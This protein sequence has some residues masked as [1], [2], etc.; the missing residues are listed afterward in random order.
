MKKLIHIVGARPQFVKLAPFVHKS[1]GMFDNIVIHTGQHY[2]AAMSAS[3]FADL[4]I[5]EPDYNL[6]VGSGN[7][8]DQTG[9]MLSGIEALLLKENPDAVI[10][11]GDTN[12]TLAGALAAAKLGIYTMH[13][14]ACLRSFNRAMPEELNRIC[15]D[16]ISDLL[17]AP[18]E[19]AMQNARLE[20]LD[21]KTHLVGDIMTDSLAYGLSKA[22]K[23]SQVLTRL[24][25]TNKEYYLLTLHRPY[26]VDDPA[27]L[28][29][30][31]CE[32][33]KLDLP[34][35]FPVHPRTTKHLIKKGSAGFKRIRTIDPQTYLDFICLLNNA[36][37][38]L[39]DSGG[40]QKEAY[41]LKVPCVTLRPETEWL[42]TVESGWN[43]LCDPTWENLSSKIMSFEVPI[44]H[45]ELFG[46]Q[47]AE[48]IIT[49]VKSK[50]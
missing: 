3:F 9:K 17:F 43:L 23:Q 48:K 36:K 35:V 16:H 25:L 38:V 6:N 7:P 47:V 14:E 34:V 20:G 22:E 8:G 18:T 42:E 50:I 40:I 33:D 1:V 10:V 4:D 39:T 31:L 41:I 19:T 32:L 46:T 12:S 2:D 27:I 28:N 15:T 26:T 37:M 21:D 11:Y 49:L 24:N 5:P 45:P 29:D 13:I 30:L 44:L